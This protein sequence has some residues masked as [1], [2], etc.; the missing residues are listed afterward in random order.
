[1]SKYG[2]KPDIEAMDRSLSMIASNLDNIV[3]EQVLK[4]CFSMM[5][6]TSL[7]TN[8]TPDSIKKLVEKVNSFNRLFPSYPLPLA[9]Q[10]A[11]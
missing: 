1:M 5:D 2:Y 9:P 7:R 3:S 11:P 6:L 10:Q 8:D 4:D